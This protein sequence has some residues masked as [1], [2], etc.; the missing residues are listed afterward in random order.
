MMP[1]FKKRTVCRDIAMR[2]EVVMLNNA[3]SWGGGGHDSREF[4]FDFRLSVMV[5]NAIV[6]VGAG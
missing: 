6:M 1:T 4:F 3:D 5:S 2:Y